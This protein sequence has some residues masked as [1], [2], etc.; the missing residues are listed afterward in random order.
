MRQAW[1]G[2]AT[3][4][5]KQLMASAQSQCSLLNSFKSMTFASATYSSAGAG[6]WDVPAI[7]QAYAANVMGTSQALTPAA[8]TFYVRRGSLLALTG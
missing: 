6:L 5:G 8:P 2:I 4:A 7:A 3:T 1:D